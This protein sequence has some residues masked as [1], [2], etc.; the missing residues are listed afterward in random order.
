[1]TEE[2]IV[3]ACTVLW[4]MVSIF[5]ENKTFTLSREIWLFCRDNGFEVPEEVMDIFYGEMKSQHAAQKTT[6]LHQQA[7]R[8]KKI[9]SKVRFKAEMKSLL[10]DHSVTECCKIL[11]QKNNMS[12][13]AV[14]QE[15]YRMN[16]K[17]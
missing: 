6:I 16:K 12:V 10:K 1:M 17:E 7:A 9:M 3:A 11:A 5:R 15:K 4:G 2:E 8:G 14:K 13:G